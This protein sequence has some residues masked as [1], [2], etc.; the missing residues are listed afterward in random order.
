VA[1]YA[2]GRPDGRTDVRR[3]RAGTHRRGGGPPSRD[4]CRGTINAHC[5]EG[6]SPGVSGFPGPL[7]PGVLRGTRRQDGAAGRPPGRTRSPARRVRAIVLG[8]RVEAVESMPAVTGP[9]R[10][11]CRW[12]PGTRTRNAHARRQRRPDRHHRARATRLFAAAAARHPVVVADGPGT[13]SSTQ[14]AADSA[15]RAE[16]T[17]YAELPEQAGYGRRDEQ[18]ASAGAERLTA[19]AGY[20]ELFSDW[21]PQG[22]PRRHVDTRHSARGRT[23]SGG[24]TRWTARGSDRTGRPLHHA[25]G[26][27]R[28][29]GGG[30]P[31]LA[32][33]H[34]PLSP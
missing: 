16:R 18:F 23:K 17:E 6:S 4:R 7:F 11:A 13:R 34:A 29:H 21:E 2:H 1:G 26:P 31:H 19:M 8:N 5:P 15:G 9:P 12:I 10:S 25:G 22:P 30:R 33:R 3:T 27:P 24:P 32:R 28:F 20:L 14:G